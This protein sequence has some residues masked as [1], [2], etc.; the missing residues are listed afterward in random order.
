MTSESQQAKALKAVNDA[1]KALED[2]LHPEVLQ[3]DA[4]SNVA[5]AR[6]ALD[7]AERNYTIAAAPT[8]QS[9]I[10]QAYS[11][12]LLAEYKITQTEE[13]LEKA[14]NQDIVLQQIRISF[15]LR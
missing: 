1:E 8:P 11:N 3:A 7:I 5:D 13:A 2:A 14:H 4:L 12:L 15:H 6:E 9:A 10:D